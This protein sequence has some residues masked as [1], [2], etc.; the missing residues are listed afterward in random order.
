MSGGLEGIV[1]ADTALAYADSAAG[2]IWIRGVALNDLVAGYGFEGAIALL[3]N[4][5]AGENLTRDGLLQTLGAARMQAF[6]RLGDWL[7]LAAQQPPE[8]TLRLCLATMPDDAPPVAIVAALSVA[9]PALVRTGAGQTPVAPDPSLASAAD[10]LRMMRGKE[11]DPAAVRA[12][13]TYWTCMAESGTGTSSFAAR[14]VAS[15]RASMAATVLGALCAFNGPLHGGAPGPTLDLLDELKAAADIDTLIECKLRAGERLMGFGHRLFRGNDPRAAALKIAL[16]EITDAADRL[17][18]VEHAE[19][20][21]AAVMDR[22]KPGRRL[23]ANIEVFAALILN[24]IGVPREAFT[25][26][27]AVTRAASWIAHG[28]EQ[29]KTGRLMR[30]ETRYVGPPVS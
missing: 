16:R 17:A 28:R 24:A 15:T 25:A 26:T 10:F 8:F 29:Q 1:V 7:P 13:E 19:A 18:F 23:P 2:K 3:W 27:F 9:V 14:V 4:G 20:R 11:A 21:I 6:A 30:P 22:L 12:L 5:L